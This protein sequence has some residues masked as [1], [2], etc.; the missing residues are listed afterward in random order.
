L[1]TAESK[2]LPPYTVL[3]HNTSADSENKIHDDA[4]AAEY[5]FKGGLVPGVAVYAYM[6]V[7]AIERWGIEWLERGSMS[8]RFQRPF[9]EGDRVTIRPS[10]GSDSMTLTA[11]RDDGVVAATANAALLNASLKPSDDLLA[12]YADLPLPS[13]ESRLPADR[14]YLKPGLNLG[15]LKQALDLA[16]DQPRLLDK[17]SEP[18]PIYRGSEAVAHP[19]VLLALANRVLMENVKLGPWIHTQSDLMNWSVARDGDEISVRGRIEKCFEARDHEFVVLD[20]LL[21]GGDRIVQQVHHT[22]IFK[23]RA[24]SRANRQR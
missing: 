13:D 24:A 20:L 10:F 12:G 16:R 22:A 21:S 2:E 6:T 4:V 23:V 5:G 19:Y 7:P 11:E 14:E 15:T 18:L 9:Y 1:S 3:A 8:V 17:I